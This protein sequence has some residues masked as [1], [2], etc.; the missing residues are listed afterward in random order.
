MQVSVYTISNP[1]LR[2]QR[3]RQVLVALGVRNGGGLLPV[4]DHDVDAL[5]V[6]PLSASRARRDSRRVS[7][8]CL[9]LTLMV[10][11][12]A[13]RKRFMYACCVML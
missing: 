3:G 12:L 13:N 4:V 8:V 10:V 11:I 7:T 6:T 5:R 1:D 2:D 9:S